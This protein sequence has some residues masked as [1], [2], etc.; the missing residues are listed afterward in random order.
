MT[1]D[2]RSN[3]GDANTRNLRCGAQH[4]IA[5]DR[6][7]ATYLPQVYA[8]F[9]RVFLSGGCQ[10][11]NGDRTCTF[12]QPQTAVEKIRALKEETGKRRHFA[13]LIG[14]DLRSEE[15]FLRLDAAG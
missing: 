5:A 9:G 11:R 4:L 3:A 13:V 6:F 15:F 12:S 1:A 14:L 10:V 8:C 2:L 7:L